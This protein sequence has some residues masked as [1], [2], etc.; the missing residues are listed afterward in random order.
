MANDSRGRG[1]QHIAQDLVK[2]S[3]SSQGFAR[4]RVISDSMVP[5]MDIDDIVLVE[6]A[7]LRDY[8]RG[9]IVVIFRNDEFITHRLV[10]LRREQWYTKGDR[11]RFLDEPISPDEVVGKVIVIEQRDS[12]IDL[13]R[14]SW[15]VINRYKAWFANLEVEFY[16][17]VRWAHRN[18]FHDN[19]IGGVK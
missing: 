14:R 11:F 7:P 3:L 9:D 6:H 18:L 8:I 19:Q 4:L 12:Q 17:V 16:K 10:R 1:Y 5:L 15:R 13:N 2:E